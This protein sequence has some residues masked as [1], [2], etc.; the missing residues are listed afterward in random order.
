MKSEETNTHIRW[1][2]W[3]GEGT[4]LDP[5]LHWRFNACFD[6]RQK[7][8][9]EGDWYRGHGYENVDIRCRTTRYQARRHVTTGVGCVMGLCETEQLFLHPN[10]TY[11]FV[12]RPGCPRCAELARYADGIVGPAEPVSSI[13]AGSAA[14]PPGADGPRSSEAQEP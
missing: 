10:Q 2:V 7:A 6:V 14:S 1:E 4:E 5:E 12:V 11:R 3:I 13:P 9:I 8:E